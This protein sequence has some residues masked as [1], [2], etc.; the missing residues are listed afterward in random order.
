MS[1]TTYRYRQ[2]DTVPFI[3]YIEEFNVD[4]QTLIPIDLTNKDVKISI[5]NIETGEQIITRE[6]CDILNPHDGQIEYSFPTNPALSAG[7]YNIKFTV[8]DATGKEAT[9]PEWEN[10]YLHIF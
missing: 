5:I 6:P 1:L 10:Q 7:M 8:I 9:F 4:K 3:Y 2:G